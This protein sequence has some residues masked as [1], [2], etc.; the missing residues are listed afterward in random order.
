MMIIL[1]DQIIIFICVYFASKFGTIAIYSLVR[2]AA[3]THSR[4]PFR[5][6]GLDIAPQRTI[7]PTIP[8]V[9]RMLR[10]DENGI[11][12]PSNIRTLILIWKGKISNM[13]RLKDER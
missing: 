8:H 9:Y 1:I 11:W 12:E 10:H 13:E 3:C 4:S 2:K 7:N 5:S 6:K